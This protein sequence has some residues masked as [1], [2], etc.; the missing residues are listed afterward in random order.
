MK[1]AEYVSHVQTRLQQESM[2]CER[3]FERQLTTDVMHVTQTELISRDMVQGFNELVKGNEIKSLR[4]MYSLLSL[5]NERDALRAAWGQYIK[6]IGVNIVMHPERDE[7]MVPELLTFKSSLDR[8]LE[9]AFDSN[10]LFSQSL[11]ESFEWFINRRR[12]KPAEYIAKYLDT[13]LRKGDKGIAGENSLDA[14]MDRVLILFRFV[15]GK[16]VFEAFYKKDLAKRL[17]LAKSASADAERSMLAKL[18]TECG[19]QFTAKLE[20]MFKDVDTS[21]GFMKSFRERPASQ[22]ERSLHVNVLSQ[23]CW[24]TYP[25]KTVVLPE[26]MVRALESYKE[27]YVKQQSGR[28]LMWRHALGHCILTADFPKVLS[29]IC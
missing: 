4:T 24:P 20:G 18:K 26:S 15:H 3:F 6:D 1:P 16:D 5:V 19:A 21:Q 17:L 27:F 22:M 29:G 28:K 7:L 2:R 11:R 23:S 13:L 10:E 25:E 14:E 8:L 12:D 9:H